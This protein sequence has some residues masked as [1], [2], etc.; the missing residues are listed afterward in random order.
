MRI[1]PI[2]EKHYLKW[3]SEGGN[4]C[5]AQSDG[6]AGRN[7]GVRRYVKQAEKGEWDFRLKAVYTIGILD[8]E[9]HL[10]RDAQVQKN[11]L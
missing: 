5:R 8:F 7:L 4:G 1:N 10:H 2:R 3:V 6:R 9:F 11:A